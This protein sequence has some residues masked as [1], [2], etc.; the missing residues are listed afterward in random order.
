MKFNGKNIRVSKLAQLGKGVKIGDNTVIH[1]HVIIGDRTV[2]CD[3]C[4]IGEPTNAYY[5]DPRY[6]QE[7]TVIGA[8]GLI[9]S[10]S[11]VYA[12]CQ[13][14]PSFQT[15]HHA[16]IREHTVVGQSTAI[17]TFSDV[18]GRV[19][20]GNYCR[21]HSGVFIC[22]GSEISDFVFIGPHAVLTDDRYPPSDDLIAPVIGEYACISARSII[23]P[24]V[25]VGPNAVVGAG[26][27]VT[28]NVPDFSLV[29]GN[30]A[31]K[32]KDVRALGT[33]RDGHPHYPWPR[34]F[35]RGM[36]WESIGFDRW[37]Q[38]NEADGR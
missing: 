19:Q 7:P 15:G 16:T 29:I 23:L 20:I 34:N 1:D 3:N 5:N 30:P 37:Q 26:S 10:F 13:I 6:I 9:R 11:I 32:I 22:Q 33:R 35:T 28:K 36:P 38:E 14:G 2:I 4:V 24:G 18:Q 21:I 17:G 31:R 25:V 27:V 8:D 12:G